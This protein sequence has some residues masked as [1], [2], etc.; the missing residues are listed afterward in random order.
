MSTHIIY[1][2]IMSLCMIEVISPAL[3][4]RAKPIQVKF[5]LTRAASEQ[6]VVGKRYKL[7]IEEVE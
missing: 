1:F 5:N 4:C 3:L 7:T 6:L 2:E